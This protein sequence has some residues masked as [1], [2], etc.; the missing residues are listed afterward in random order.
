MISLQ[1]T[2]EKEDFINFYTF[3][4]WEEK[5]KRK[6]RI[7]NALKQIAIYFFIVSMLFFLKKIYFFGSF[8][9]PILGL[10]LFLNLLPFFT[11]K[12][13]ITRQAEIIADDP[14]NSNMF[15][16]ISLTFSDTGIYTKDMYCENTLKWHAIIKKI[17]IPS[18]YFLHTNAFNAI[19][20]P[21]NCFKNTDEKTT[22]DKILS[23]N[24]SLEAELKDEIN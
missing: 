20:I 18:Y 17:E 21:K 2:L 16:E 11:G 9:I 14:D 7:N 12:S 3:I 13:Q 10:L 4:N 8:S 5:G 6:R 19:I 24:L 22:F 1:Y 23:R 15:K